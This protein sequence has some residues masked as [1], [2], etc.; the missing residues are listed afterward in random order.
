MLVP[1][2]EAAMTQEQYIE[3]MNNAQNA[4]DYLEEED[5]DQ[6]EHMEDEG[7]LQMG[8]DGDEGE[9]MMD[10]GEGEE[11][12]MDSQMEDGRQ[13]VVHELQAHMDMDDQ[14]DYQNQPI[15][16]DRQGE[17]Q[18]IEDEELGEEMEGSEINQELDEDEQREL[19]RQQMQ[20]MQEEYGEGEDEIDAADQEV[21]QMMNAQ[22]PGRQQYDENDMHG[23][24]QMDEDGGE[25]EEDD[26]EQYELD[27]QQFQQVM[28]GLDHAPNNMLIDQ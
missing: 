19:I 25:G 6:G 14:D 9:E 11:D 16:M 8:D 27:E 22:R 26:D 4:E 15:N 7:Q 18:I 3:A 28:Q 21:H 2:R 10:E 20:N 23:E 1:G 12:F 24:D 13:Q 17:Q 5:E